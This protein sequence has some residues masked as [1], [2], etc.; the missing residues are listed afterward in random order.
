M[1]GRTISHYKIIEKIGAGG[2][3][4]VYKAEDT[5]LNR[6]VALK[7][8]PEH[9]TKNKENI[10][11][12]EIEAK[13]AA[14]LNHPNIVTIHDVIETDDQFC[15]VMEYVDGIS[16]KSKISDGIFDFNEVLDITIQICD[17]LSEAH[18]AGIVHRDI[19]S[20]NILID[21]HGRVKILDFGLAK[22]KKSGKLTVD[23]STVGTVYY[24][25][26]EQ[27]RG[28]EVDHRS[29]IWSL[30]IV[31]YEIL[32]GQLPFEGDYDQAVMYSI[33]N[34][35]PR[36]IKSTITSVPALFEQ[37]VLKCIEK[38]PQ[39]RYSTV[40][41]L[42]LDVHNLDSSM[43]KSKQ[44]V[45]QQSS[46]KKPLNKFALNFKTYIT[47][48]FIGF[49]LIISYFIFE[50][51]QESDQHISVAVIDFVNETDEKEL[52]GLSGMLITALE[53]SRRFTVLTRS[54]LFDILKQLGKTN[55]EQ[56]DESLGRQICN[57]ANVNTLA[58]ASIRKFGRIYAIDF[59]LLNV[60][61]NEYFFTINEQGQGQESIPAMIDN[62]SEK[63]RMELKEKDVEI[64]ESKLHV[65]QITTQNL[66]AYQHYFKGQEYIDKLK[67]EDAS[68]EFKKAIALDSTFG[69]AYYRLSYAISWN[70]GVEQVAIEPVQMALKYIDRIPVKER[71]LVRAEYAQIE[72]G[73]KEGIEILKQ[74][75]EIYPNDKEMIYN[76]GDWSYHAGKF[77]DSILYLTRVLRLDSTHIRTI[78]HLTMN[79]QDAQ[80]YE[81]M[82]FFARKYIN[83]SPSDESFTFLSRAYAGLGLYE[84]GLE[85]LQNAMESLPVNYL[86]RAISNLYAFQGKYK[87]AENEA[88]KL[89]SDD[90]PLEIQLLG[91]DILSQIYP[92][93]GKYK[94]A[95]AGFDDLI[96]RYW[97]NKDTTM[98]LYM[99]TIKANLIAMAWKDTDRAWQE[100]QKTFPYQNQINHALYWTNL[101]LLSISCGEYNLAKKTS[102]YIPARW[103]QQTV[104]ALIHYRKEECN[105]AE[106]ESLTD[107]ILQTCPKF[108][109]PLLLYNLAECQY[110]NG[111][112]NKALK[113]ILKLQTFYNNRFGFR[114][115]YFPRSFYLI[116]KIYEKKGQTNLAIENYEKFLDIWNNADRDLPELI[117][118][119]KRYENLTGAI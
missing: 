6:T 31:L 32:S 103:W 47:L 67:F 49:L 24:M 97:Q 112:L 90:Y 34:D 85:T 95:L 16:I 78:Q 43:E 56:I 25:S 55:V 75:E 89:I 27:L 8:L 64:D 107:S 94:S 22:L 17:G 77:D 35:K 21:S 65:A 83:I 104:R 108:I 96:T 1:I 86:S 20:D 39:D 61:K 45:H 100:A 114:A 110:R 11:R 87:E 4:I 10:E 73:F 60:K 63:T 62:I 5:K 101:S 51:E 52:N 26:P 57:Q 54:R 92:Y 46:S 109:E 36:P 30:G 48:L 28:N 98:A 93:T 91:Y 42:C 117:D 18:E 80:Q 70:L 2:M 13:A 113:H 84:E 58:M 14:A 19:K 29:D 118:A 12:F 40:K 38:N 69:L 53:Q 111:Q 74:M 50:K 99:H 68:D 15:I 33:T 116:A 88:K 41:E 72:N 102:L 119:M 59:K 106:V 82:L 115:I 7:F 3:G 23:T 37:I 44:S 79:Y 76:I 71:Y 66:E 81:N 105:M 9:L